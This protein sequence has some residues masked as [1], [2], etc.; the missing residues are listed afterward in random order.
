MSADKAI[1][2]RRV[3]THFDPDYKMSKKDRKKLLSRVLYSLA[4]FKVQNWQFVVIEDPEQRTLLRKASWDQAQVTSASMVVILCTNLKAWQQEPLNCWH[5]AHGYFNEFITP[6]PQSHYGNLDQMQRDEVMR[7]CGIT[8]EAVMLTAQSM[9]YDACSIN[10]FDCDDVADLINLPDDHAV[11]SL[12]TIG[13][14]IDGP[15]PTE[16][17]PSTKELVIKNRF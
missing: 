10:G 13:K 4:S 15:R 12:I 1:P 8:A 5:P 14:S 17:P 2:V 3:V 9:G 7:S 11:C 6:S 16:E